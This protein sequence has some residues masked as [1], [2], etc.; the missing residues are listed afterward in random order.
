MFPYLLGRVP[1]DGPLEFLQPSG[2]LVTEGGLALLVV[3]LPAE[4]TVAGSG[5]S[6]LVLASHGC[7][8]VVVVVV[9]S[10]GGLIARM[11]VVVVIVV[12]I[13]A[14]VGLD[15]GCKDF[16]RWCSCWVGSSD[17]VGFCKH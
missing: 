11:L 15:D 10:G 6:G 3:D 2:N 12:A 9:G 7:I 14:A 8:V 17:R 5:S 16:C 4:E 13:V 1:R